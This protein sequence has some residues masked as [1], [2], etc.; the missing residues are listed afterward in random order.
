MKTVEEKINAL[1]ELIQFN[2]DRID[3]YEKASGETEVIDADLRLLFS[4]MANDSRSYR[5]ELAAQVAQL[6]GRVE[7]EG[8][9]SA[10]IHRAWMDLK[11]AVTGS[12]RAAILG[13]CEFGE[14]AIVEAYDAVLNDTE[15]FTSEEIAIVAEQRNGLR[16][17]E[18]AIS[19][20][21]KLNNAVS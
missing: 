19:E 14:N 17:A 13:S 6:G 16:N 2:N 11:T 20:Y 1:N 3:G 10:S 7:T 18:V 21:K 8:S 9:V 12:D 5:K 4:K 15:S